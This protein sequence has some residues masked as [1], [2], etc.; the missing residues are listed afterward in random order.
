MKIVRRIMSMLMALALIMCLQVPVKAADDGPKLSMTVSETEVSVG[1]T[2]KLTI[3]ADEDFLTRG[4]GFTVYYDDTVLELDTADSTAVA[5]FTVNGPVQVKGKSAFRVSFMPGME[6]AQVSA[7][8]PL[9]VV[10]FKALAVSEAASFEMGAAY[11]YDT[12]LGEIPTTAADKVSV[13]VKP[14][15]TYIPVTGVTL[16]KTELTLEEV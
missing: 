12:A 8:E 15:V 9:A 4:S 14:S 3:N 6:E 11:L 16:D 7:S 5:P 10:S 13:T 1:D 2:V